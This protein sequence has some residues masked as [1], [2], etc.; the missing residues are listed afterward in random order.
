MNNGNSSIV[1]STNTMLISY[2]KSLERIMSDLMKSTLNVDTILE[3]GEKCKQLLSGVDVAIK[4]FTELRISL[5]TFPQ[6][7]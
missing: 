4:D 2:Y 3:P 7:L 1:L 6:S 5:G